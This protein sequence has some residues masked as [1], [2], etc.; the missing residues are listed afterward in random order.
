MG[1]R[2]SL[3]FVVHQ[4]KERFICSCTGEEGAVVSRKAAKNRFAQQRYRQRQKEKNQSIQQQ[5]QILNRR[6]ASLE[7]ERTSLSE[8]QRVL[9][10]LAQFADEKTITSSVSTS[11]LLSSPDSNHQFITLKS[12]ESSCPIFDK[13][14]C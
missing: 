11:P 12:I 4:T 14:F 1:A 3:H 9:Q 8:R 7:I 6:V 5:L 2:E 13:A 10:R